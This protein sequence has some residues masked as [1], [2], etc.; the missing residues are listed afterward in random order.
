MEG[1]V[2]KK[3][4]EKEE[5]E[6]DERRL[7]LALLRSRQNRRDI[8]DFLAELEAEKYSWAAS[9]RGGELGL[10]DA[11]LQERSSTQGGGLASRRVV[12]VDSNH[13]SPQGASSPSFLP[14]LVASKDPDPTRRKPFSQGTEKSPGDRA[15]KKAQNLAVGGDHP[16]SMPVLLLPPVVPSAPIPRKPLKDI[17]AVKHRAPRLEIL[18]NEKNGGGRPQPRSPGRR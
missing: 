12:D 18:L 11:H 4:K 14:P 13:R 2:K 16:R 15:D 7:A 5:E 9:G 1:A 17:E 10:Y 8:S 3:E 6:E